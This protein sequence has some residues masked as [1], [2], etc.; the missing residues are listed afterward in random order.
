MASNTGCTSDGELAMTFRMSAVAFWLIPGGAELA[1]QPCERG[2]RSG[3]LS[4]G[5]GGPGPGKILAREAGAARLRAVARF[6]AFFPRM[7][8]PCSRV[9]TIASPDGGV[10]A[11]SRRISAPG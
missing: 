9:G 5:T 7:A 1:F 4:L 11:R 3:G 6:P 8:M 10:Q 2:C